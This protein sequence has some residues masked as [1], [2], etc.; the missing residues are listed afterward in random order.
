MES[1]SSQQYC[2]TQL[3]LL[4]LTDLKAFIFWVVSPGH[5]F[6]YELWL[7]LAHPLHM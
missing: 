5:N 7:E 6:G 4:L 1:T 2:N 3:V